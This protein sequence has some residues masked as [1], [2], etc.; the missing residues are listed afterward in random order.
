MPI[1]DL[2]DDP[3]ARVLQGHLG[4]RG[5]ARDD[6]EKLAAVELA[7]SDALDALPDRLFALVGSVDGQSLRKYAMHDPGHL[8]TSILY[9]LECGAQLPPDVRQKVAANLITACGWYETAPPAALTKVAFIG[10]ALNTGLALTAVPGKVRTERAKSQEHDAG[11]RA[12]QVSGLKQAE[13]AEHVSDGNLDRAWAALDRFIRGNTK[14]LAEQVDEFGND[15]PNAF[16]DT[17]VK[18][19]NTAGTEVHSF[20]GLSNDPRSSPPAKR[21]ATAPKVSMAYQAVGD[22][23]FRA[24]MQEAQGVRHYALPH[25]ELYPIDTEAQVKRASAYFDEYGREFPMDERRVY[26]MNV[27]TRADELGVEVSSVLTKL[28]SGTYGPYARAEL[29]GRIHAL[30]GT[31]KTAAYEVLLENLDETP[32]IVAYDMLKQADEDTGVDQGYGRP[33]TGFKDPLSAIFGAPERPIYS[34]AGK[35]CYVNEEILRSYSKLVPD[36]DKVIEKD[37]SQKFV[38]DPIKAFDK[39]PDAKKIIIARLANGEAFRWI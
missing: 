20:G 18:E 7:D 9:F 32:P 5:V 27:A 34:W 28:A 30:E 25:D 16:V 23:H 3:G 26:A 13:R 37:W 8:A 11:V 22:F 19:A 1:L 21:F 4:R 15:Y 33:V 6:L 14:G 35:G 39:L 10:A 24:P 17:G 29:E 38:D 12:A 31:D 36:L 2:Y